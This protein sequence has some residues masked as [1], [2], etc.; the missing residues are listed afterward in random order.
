MATRSELLDA[1]LAR[2]AEE[3]RAWSLYHLNRLYGRLDER[4]LDASYAII[5][6]F[7]IGLHIASVTRTLDTLDEY[8]HLKARL[9]GYY[10]Q[11]DWRNSRLPLTIQL[12]SGLPLLSYMRIA[13]Q[14]MKR[15]IAGGMDVGDA[16]DV[17]KGRAAQVYRSIT[18]KLVRDTNGYRSDL[19]T[20]SKMAADEAAASLPLDTATMKTLIPPQFAPWL[21]ELENL[22]NERLAP[23]AVP[24][25]FIDE[26]RDYRETPRARWR[27]V[28][29]AGA[30]GYCLA[31]AS[32]GSVYYS[33]RTAR[34]ADHANC[35]CDVIVNMGLPA[36]LI[37]EADYRRL[38]E[39]DANGKLKSWR[40]STVPG[41]NRGYTRRYTY[42]Y[43]LEDVNERLGGFAV[44]RGLTPP[45]A[46]WGS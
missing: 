11:F 13:P 12:P 45:T 38:T 34:S 7:L 21:D 26:L 28:P 35:R 25:R 37:S 32:R 4:N 31:L 19:L 20:L 6:P 15:L 16:I 39:R 40:I 27:R 33:E 44:Y 36:L 9:G 46:K 42:E 29:S 2:W 18:H 43:T 41:K 17:S 3:N 1:E 5:L 30:C 10:L 14:G 24:D 22:A 8:W 23:E